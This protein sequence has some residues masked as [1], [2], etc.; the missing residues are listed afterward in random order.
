MS[1]LIKPRHHLKPGPHALEIPDYR[2]NLE[3][4]NRSIA[5][6]QT[7]EIATTLDDMGSLIFDV[8][9]KLIL[10]EK[11]GVQQYLTL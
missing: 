11:T 6:G 4:Y 8:Q 7:V 2:N 9:T 3:L 5:L 1:A 10:H